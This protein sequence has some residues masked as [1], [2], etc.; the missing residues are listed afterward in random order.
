MQN[1]GSREAAQ[2]RGSILVIQRR[3]VCRPLL[4]CS[5]DNGLEDSVVVRSREKAG[6]HAQASVTSRTPSP[7]EDTNCIAVELQVH[8]CNSIN[9]LV[10]I[11]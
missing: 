11:A 3:A 9:S 6:A 7:H 8:P 1:H 2:A 4:R 5:I 10:E